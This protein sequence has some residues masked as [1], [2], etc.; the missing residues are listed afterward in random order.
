[1][2]ENTQA[3]R[4]P[5]TQTKL[6]ALPVP[7]SGRSVYHDTRTSGLILRITP[8]GVKT[9]S[10]YGKVKGRP[11]RYTLGKFPQVSLDQARNACNVKAGEVASGGDPAAERRAARYE[12]T[13]G[14]LWT[15]WLEIHA[16]PHKKSWKGD[17]WL[18]SHFLKPWAERRL[19]SIKKGDVL[20]LHAKVGEEN[21][22]YLANRAIILLKSI[23]SK[24]IRDWDYAGVNPAL[25]V[26]L[27]KEE[28]RDRFL[29]AGELPKLF[30]SLDAEANTDFR[31]FFKIALLCG[32][33]RGNVLSMRWQD[34]D[35]ERGL[36]RIPETKS[37]VPVVVPLVAAAVAIL[38]ARKLAG[39]VNQYVFS[40]RGKTG[41]LAEPKTAWK[42]ILKRAGL[43]NVRIH[44]LRRTLGSWQ[45]L[46]GTPLQVIGKSLGHTQMRTTEI[47]ARLTLDPVRAS[48]DRATT[49]ILEAASKPVEPADDA[50][51]A[52]GGFL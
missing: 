19:S 31:D 14:G 22:R 49:A 3:K 39:I 40:G 51:P 34:V 47:Y 21:G 41:H 9:F 13:V 42:R 24:A 16:K 45:A 38:L 23:Y 7:T 18:Y 26:T 5:F 6:A 27:F 15:Y 37:G 2:A 35:L 44:D 43:E 25:G 1:M 17:E 10:F 8:S 30:N 52:A 12:R 50:K 29:S 48:V 46:G 4:F 20:A 32:A 28:K 33:R 36:W 11:Q